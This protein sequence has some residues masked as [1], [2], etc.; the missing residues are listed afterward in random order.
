[1]DILMTLTDLVLQRNAY[2]P[3]VSYSCIL[4]NMLQ[5]HTHSLRRALARVNADPQ[6]HNMV[7][8]TSLREVR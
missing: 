4:G 8:W 3:R 7:Y 6:G 5:L 1:M 2:R